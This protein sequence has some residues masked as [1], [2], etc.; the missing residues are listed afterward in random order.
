MLILARKKGE[1]IHINDDIVITVMETGD[2]LV[3]LGIR[4]PDA[5]TVKRGE[6]Y[7]Q[8]MAEREAAGKEKEVDGN[9]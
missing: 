3:K 8:I 2:R 5:A 7:R 1:T 9:V 6:V 4:A